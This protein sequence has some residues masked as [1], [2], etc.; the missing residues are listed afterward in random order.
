MAI[1]SKEIRVSSYCFFVDKSII[2]IIFFNGFVR[3]SR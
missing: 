1:V 3:L 2:K